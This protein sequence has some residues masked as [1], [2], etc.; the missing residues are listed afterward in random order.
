MAVPEIIHQ[1]VI[2]YFQYMFPV[3]NAPDKNIQLIWVQQGLLSRN[4][5]PGKPTA[6]FHGLRLF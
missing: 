6:F 1:G 4:L 5:Q 2:S 3:F